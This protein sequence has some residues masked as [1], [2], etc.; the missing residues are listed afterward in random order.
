MSTNKDKGKDSQ[1]SWLPPGCS[2]ETADAMSAIVA[3][4]KRNGKY[5]SVDD[6]ALAMLARQLDVFQCASAMVSAEGVMVYNAKEQLIPNP[7]LAIMNQAEVMCLK[8][9]KEYGL[10]ALSRKV[11]GSMDQSAEPSPL[12]AFI[13][14]SRH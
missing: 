12:E 13:A 10:T 2:K 5:E 14:S 9:L 7:K 1:P 3:F 11:L 6:T 4:L 8:I